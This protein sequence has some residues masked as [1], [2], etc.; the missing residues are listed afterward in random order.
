MGEAIS[1]PNNALYRGRPTY[2]HLITK[3]MGPATGYGSDPAALRWRAK[4]GKTGTT[5]VEQTDQSVV[6]CPQCLGRTPFVPLHQ[7]IQRL[8]ALV[9]EIEER[10]EAQPL[11]TLSEDIRAAIQRHREEHG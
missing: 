11:S 2:R 1:I 9:S 6:T 7:R 4:C 3:V 5:L 8:E 10:A